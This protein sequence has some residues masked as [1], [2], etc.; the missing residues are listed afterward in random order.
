MG[1]RG[2]DVLVDLAKS[3]VGERVNLDHSSVVNFDNVEVSTFAALRSAATGEN[4]R[5]LEFAIST[6]GWL[7]LRNVV[8]KLIV[9]LPELVAVLL[10]KVLGGLGT[11][12]LVDVD[13][14]VRVSSLYS[15]DQ[16]KSLLE[17]V[18]SVEEDEVDI[19]FD[20]AVELR[21]HI[22]DGESSETE[23]GCLVK[24]RKRSNAPFE[25]V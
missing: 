14:Q 18:K 7:D 24:A 6:L 12:R 11:L 10:G 4:S 1:H 22:V 8:I 15:V 20:W 21:D 19:W 17:V 13:G 9:G 25:D 3:P 23:S 2:L 16:V 5:Y